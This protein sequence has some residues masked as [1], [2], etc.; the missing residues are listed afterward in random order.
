[1]STNSTVHIGVWTNWSGGR[2]GGSTITL[3]KGAGNVLIAALAIFIQLTGARSWSIIS[4]IAHQIRASRQAK[5]GLYHQQQAILR[6]NNSDLSTIWQFTRIGWAWRRQLKTFRKSAILLLTANI[7]LIAFLAAGLLASHFTK[8]SSE[9][10]LAR[11]SSCGPWPINATGVNETTLPHVI[12]YRSYAADAMQSSKEYVESCLAESQSLPECDIYKNPQIPWTETRTD[13]PFADGFCLGSANTSLTMTTGLIDSRNDNGI[14]GPNKDRVQWR[15]TAT[16]IPINTEGY[17]EI[18]FSNRTN[19]NGLDGAATLPFNYTALY[20]GVGNTPAI[21]LGFA[22][23]RLTNATY[24]YTNFRDIA[25][26]YNE[27]QAGYDIST[28]EADGGMGWQAIPELSIM[29]SST[30]LVFASFYGAYINRSEDLW[31]SA[32]F[33][34][35]TTVEVTS[36]QASTTIQQYQLDNPISPL[37]CTEQIQF[38][39]PAAGPNHCTPY[40]SAGQMTFA[41][42]DIFV[43]LFKNNTRQIA[44]ANSIFTAASNSRI[45]AVVGEL[46]KPLLAE[47]MMSGMTSLPLSADQWISEVRNWFNIGLANTQRRI[48]DYATGPAPQYT[49]FVPQNQAYKDSALAWLCDSQVIQRNDFTNFRTWVVGLVFGFGAIIIGLS[50]CL[51]TITG[52]L[53]ARRHRGEWRQRAWWSEETLQ[54]QRRVYQAIGISGWDIGEDGMVPT[55]FG[56]KKWM[57]ISAWEENVPTYPEEKR[58]GAATGDAPS[59][60]GVGKGDVVTKLVSVTP[61]SPIASDSGS[62]IRRTRSNSV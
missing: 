6:N 36:G 50:L 15:R 12:G 22:D 30:L 40:L 19:I 17:V 62:S 44:T 53:R 49:Q 58:R 4:F 11:S 34:N 24:I 54:M 8:A 45:A 46:E 51:E 27:N 47:S 14:N 2:V 25:G 18:G 37:G 48:V 56:E 39:N 29:N 41:Q 52:R 5:D 55:T 7:H 28:Q 61:T 16:C 60:R 33:R 42:P 43:Q 57:S 9:V 32:Q 10:L 59:I 26:D 3:T 13:C 21:Y 35:I 38:C 1:M 23:P 20:Y 31:L